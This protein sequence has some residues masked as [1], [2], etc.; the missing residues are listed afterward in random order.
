MKRNKFLSLAIALVFTTTQAFAASIGD[1]NVDLGKTTSTGDKSITFKGPTSSKKL[2]GSQAGALGYNGN[3]LSI[4]DGANTAN[5]T[6]TFDKGASSPFFQYNFSTGAIDTGNLS[7]LNHTGN[8][9]NVGDGTNTNKVLKFNKGASSPEIRYNSSTGKLQ[10]TNDAAVYKDIGSGSGGGGGIN[11]FSALNA[12]FES[13]SPP[14]NYTASGGTFAAESSTPLFDLQSGKW[15]ASALN[16]TLSSD[17]VVIPRGFIGQKCTADIYY[18]WPSGVAGDLSFQILDTGVVTATVAVSPTTGSNIGKAQLAFDCPDSAT[19]TLQWR[20]LANVADPA[21]ITFDNVF[22]GVGKNTSQITQA[23]IIGEAKFVATTSCIWSRNSTSQGAFTPTAACPG[24]TVVTNPGPGTILTTDANLPQITVSDLPPGTYEV[25]VGGQNNNDAGTFAMLSLWDGSTRSG[26]VGAGD[27]TSATH[28]RV[29]GYFVYST[30]GSRTFEL[31]GATSSGNVSVYA[32]QPGPNNN[33]QWTIKRWPTNPAS[34]IN[35]ETT[36]GA[37]SGYHTNNCSWARTSTAYGDPT[38]DATCDLIEQVNSG[39]GTV[40]TYG[41]ALPGIVFT[42]KSAGTYWVCAIPKFDTVSNQNAAIRLQ[43]IGGA[44]IAEANQFDANNGQEKTLTLCGLYSVTSV[45]QKT[46][47]LQTKVSSGTV[48]IGT[49]VNTG[50]VYWSIFPISQGFP[51]PVFA[52]L[53]NK[54]G[55]PGY[56]NDTKFCSFYVSNGTGVSTP[57][58][59]AGC[60]T[61]KIKGGCANVGSVT[62]SSAGRYTYTFPGGYWNVPT[63]VSCSL[64]LSSGG[65]GRLWPYL[66]DDFNASSRSFNFDNSG[67]A[68]NDASFEVF[69]HGR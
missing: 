2:K 34:A 60:T 35:L 58:S 54:V 43:E 64:A 22:V 52:E 40:T 32:N 63:E 17:T 39:F 57:C 53:Q 49:P 31:H 33:L 56:G 62:R 21:Q 6:F 19:D 7:I 45:A 1:D 25:E 36:G 50:T 9:L 24:P 65:S 68:G 29:K 26:E 18:R 44:T 30:S 47:A 11:A 16:Q 38:A 20:W 61:Q 23:S 66:G 4:G 12:D 51:A 14:S 41:A 55:T 27:S 28:F 59:S 5:K 10:F 46:L 15:D 37:W 67:A 3:S 69:C 48:T 13:A 8:N 42:P